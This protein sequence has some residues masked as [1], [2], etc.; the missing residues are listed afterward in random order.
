M[1]K[2][3]LLSHKG[4][5][6]PH[7]MRGTAPKLGVMAQGCGANAL[8]LGGWGPNVAKKKAPGIGRTA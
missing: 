5:P 8:S 1:Y 4:G 7:H 2:P 6:S 3:M